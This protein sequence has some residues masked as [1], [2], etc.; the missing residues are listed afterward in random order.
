M[1]SADMPINDVMRRHPRTEV[2]FTRHFGIECAGCPAQAFES[3][4]L[5]CR[6]H[7]ADLKTV[8]DD[9]NAVTK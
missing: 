7:D 6:L 3:I 9:L 1:I 4:A 8:L 5:A 2:V